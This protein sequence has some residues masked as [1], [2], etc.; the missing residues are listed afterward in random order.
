MVYT[1]HKNGDD[2]GMVYGIAVP[3][4]FHIEYIYIESIGVDIYDTLSLVSLSKLEEPEVSSQVND[5]W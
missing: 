2:W 4:L 5:K 1:T 3:T